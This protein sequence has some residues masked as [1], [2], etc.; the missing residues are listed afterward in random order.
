MR[1]VWP[2]RRPLNELAPRLNAVRARLRMDA[3]ARAALRVQSLHGRT[4]YR[5]FV[6]VGLART[7]STLLVNLLNAHSGVLAFGE[8]F[9]SPDAIGWD[10]RPFVGYQNPTLLARYRSDPNKFLEAEVFRRWPRRYEA[11]G[12]KLFYY[13][14]RQRRFSEVWDHLRADRDIRIVHIRR[15]NILK[16]Y[17]SLKI[18]HATD[19]WSVTTTPLHEPAAIRLDAEECCRHFEFVREAEAACA[20]FFGHNHVL[21]IFYEDL[22]EDEDRAV[23]RVQNFLGIRREKLTATLVRQRKATL[24]RAIA[25]FEEL[26]GAFI[27]TSWEP[28][29]YDGIERPSQADRG[30]VT[31]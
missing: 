25:N 2:L 18:A 9:R 7:G 12:F 5:R 29:F 13:H 17:L 20:R 24:P 6:I 31:R 14:A 8:L 30:Q 15:Q 10:V 1:A 28:F 4:D 27:G 21:D 16:Q 23:R 3:W 11:V 22:T 19:V 26:K